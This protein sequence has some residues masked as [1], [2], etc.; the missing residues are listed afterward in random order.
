MNDKLQKIYEKTRLIARCEET[1]LAAC[2]ALNNSQRNQAPP[3]QTKLDC[4]KAVVGAAY[5]DGGFDAA[6]MVMDKLGIKAETV[7]KQETS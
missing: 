1:G 6:K 2:I 4:I 5:L 3:A 7:A